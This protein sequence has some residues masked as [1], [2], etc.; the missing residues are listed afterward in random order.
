MEEDPSFL[1]SVNYD[2]VIEEMKSQLESL[3]YAIL[4]QF[5]QF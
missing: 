4:Y 3:N 1:S 5:I 2:C